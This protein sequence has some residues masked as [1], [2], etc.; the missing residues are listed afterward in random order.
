MFAAARDNLRLPDVR[1]LGMGGNGAALSVFFNP[2][3]LALKERKE[4]CAGYY[5]RYSVKELAS[6]SSG[7]TFPNKILPTGLHIASFGYDE[8][9]ESMFRLSVGKPLNETWALG[10]SVQYALLQS[11]LFETDAARLSADIG[12]TFRPAENWLLTLAAINMPS[13][14]LH[15]EDVDSERI[16][17]Q[18]AELGI[19]WQMNDDLLISGGMAYSRD[20]PFEVSLGMEYQ[21]LADFRLRTGL[22]T[23]PLR[24]SLGAGYGFA[25]WMM[26]VV[27]IY[28]AALGISTGLSVSFSF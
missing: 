9:R 3:L 4:V 14:T 1:A 10:V 25:G 7:L 8:Y 16:A 12:L 21:P 22:R 24:P 20:A 11:A 18:L 13:V 27:M 28:H 23:A 19:G 26:D 17:S 5:N 6:V 2:A 15:S